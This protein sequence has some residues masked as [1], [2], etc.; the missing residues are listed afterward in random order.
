MAY[1]RTKKFV[2]LIAE[3]QTRGNHVS[4]LSDIVIT[5]REHS[6]NTVQCMSVYNVSVCVESIL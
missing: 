2:L 6:S 4:Y 1:L 3:G 5:I